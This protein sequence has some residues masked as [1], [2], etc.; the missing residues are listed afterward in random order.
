MRISLPAP[1]TLLS[2][3][4]C[5]WGRKPHHWR[6]TKEFTGRGGC[7][8][9]LRIRQRMILK[10]ER[11]HQRQRLGSGRHQYSCP[12]SWVSMCK[13]PCFSGAMSWAHTHS[14]DPCNSWDNHHSWHL[15]SAYHESGSAISIFH[16]PTHFP[17]RVGTAPV[18]ILETVNARHTEDKKPW[19][20]SL[21]RK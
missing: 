14:G 20:G 1:R 7:P 19:P 4:G 18:T 8:S 6:H 5:S 12:W 17:Y 16:I 21:R 10:A 3:R 11:A 2:Q 9:S 15:L 13:H